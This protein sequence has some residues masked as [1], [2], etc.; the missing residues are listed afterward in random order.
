MVGGQK[1]IEVGWEQKRS[2]KGCKRAVALSCVESNPGPFNANGMLP[3][4]HD[5]T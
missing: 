2:G 1:G 4:D 3:L 5:A